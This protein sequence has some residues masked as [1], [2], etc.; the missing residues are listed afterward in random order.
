MSSVKLK[1]QILDGYSGSS[2]PQ[3]FTI[4]EDEIADCEDEDALQ[5]MIE[6][7]V[8]EDFEQK[9][10]PGWDDSE[11]QKVIKVWKELRENEIS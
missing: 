7:A 11:I 3:Y 6:S 8:R 10:S 4:S 2:R 1:W 9:V 5:Q